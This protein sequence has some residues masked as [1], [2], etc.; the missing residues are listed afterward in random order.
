MHTILA[1]LLVFLA[2]TFIH[3]PQ[4]VSAIDI[5]TN[6]DINIIN[7]IARSDQLLN[8]GSF[9]Q[10]LAVAE[11][12]T[13]ATFVSIATTS[14]SSTT[15]FS[16]PP[17]HTRNSPSLPAITGVTITTTP[18]RTPTI[19]SNID[20]DSNSP[21]PH[22]FTF[23]SPKVAQASSLTS[24][25]PRI[26]T[27]QPNNDQDSN[28]PSPSLSKKTLITFAIATGLITCLVTLTLLGIILFVRR[29]HQIHHSARGPSE[30]SPSHPHLMN[31]V[32]MAETP[33]PSGYGQG[34]GLVGVQSHESQQ[35]LDTLPAYGLA[36]DL[37]PIYDDQRN[38]GREVALGLSSSGPASER[39]NN[40]PD[41]ESDESDPFQD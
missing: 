20:Q 16:L 14:S 8:D 33:S 11:S 19:Q 38:M 1:W 37:P 15:S 26:P 27:I 24:T 2:I 31:E 4:P 3:L 22:D 39:L 25:S 34:H 35:S 30:S 23:L 13:P 9:V 6:H 41:D 10:D 18:T 40:H 12:L 29:R 36:S 28:S 17:F 7:V 32:L 5:Y 21:S